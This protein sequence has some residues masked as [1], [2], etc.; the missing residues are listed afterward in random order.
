VLAKYGH[1]ESIPADWTT[2]HVNAARPGVLAATLNRE[3]E[4]ALLFRDLATLRTDL[5]LFDDVDALRWKGPTS[6]F[7]S[8]AAEL[9]AATDQ[10]RRSRDG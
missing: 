4:Q 1:L 9:D 5:A 6:G 8:L 7:R 10:A 3:R 2:W